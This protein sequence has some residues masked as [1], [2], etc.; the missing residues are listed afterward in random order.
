MNIAS[1]R[2]LRLALGASLALW[3]S[4]AL[5]WDMSY[6]APVFAIMLLTLPTPPPAFK[7]GAVFVLALSLSIYAGL[8]LLPLLIYQLAAGTLVLTVLLF[9]SFYYPAKGGPAV[10]GTF[11]TVGLTLTAAIGRG[12]VDAFV[13]LA[14]AVTLNATIGMA[15]VWLAHALLPDSM[16]K[17]AASAAAPPPAAAPDLAAARRS[18]FRSLLVVLPVCVWLLLSSGNAAYAPF[19]IKVA[20]MGQQTHAQ[21]TA[22]AGKSLIAS[23]VIGG[24]GAIICW[25]VL[26]LWPSLILYTLLVAVAG[27]IIGRRIFKDHGLHPQGATWSYGYVTL[28]VILAPAVLDSL[29]GSSADVKFWERLVM[30]A[31]ATVYGVVAVN[32]FDAFWSDRGSTA[33]RQPS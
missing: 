5:A 31:G 32:V 23:T 7:G 20:S 25:Q 24:A 13:A 30:F 22:A 29:G 26:R 11:V 1:V 18:A 3:F 6:V 14:A 8:L 12:S 21:D 33:R 4:Q 17:V 9:W 16:A 27:L 2:T 28:L 10:V 15:F 19:M